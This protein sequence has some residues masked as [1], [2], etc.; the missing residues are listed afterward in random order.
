MFTVFPAPSQPPPYPSSVQ[1]FVRET[2]YRTEAETFQWSFVLEYLASP[3]VVAE[4]STRSF[5]AKRLHK[6]ARQG[7]RT[8]SCVL[9]SLFSFLFFS[10]AYRVSLCTFCTRARSVALCL[11][12]CVWGGAIRSTAAT[13]TA[14]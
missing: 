11:C 2:K 1:H 6:R 10:K 12:V 13:G 9:C 5:S 14:A 8:R 7:A 3:E 4:V